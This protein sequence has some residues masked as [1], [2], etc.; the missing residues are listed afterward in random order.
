MHKVSPTLLSQLDAVAAQLLAA[1][2]HGVALFDVIVHMD[3]HPTP[4]WTEA[5]ERDPNRRW[6]SSLF[7]TEEFGWV[8]CGQ[9]NYGHRRM[10]WTKTVKPPVVP[11]TVILPE[12]ASVCPKPPREDMQQAIKAL[13]GVYS[14]AK[15][16][17]LKLNKRDQQ[18]VRDMMEWVRGTCGGD[19]WEQQ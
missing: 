15:V 1:Q 17:G 13:R 12:T 14:Y 9:T 10:L 2:P 19:T 5:S 8:P 3:Q 6:A 18:V 7:R 4:E 11:E 16:H